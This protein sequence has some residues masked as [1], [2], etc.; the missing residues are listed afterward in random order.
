M[1]CRII[2][3]YFVL[4]PFAFIDDIIIF[5]EGWYDHL[6]HIKNVLESLRK[7]H[8]SAKPSKC[9]FAFLQ[10]EFLAHIVGNGDV[11]PTQEKI[12]AIQKIP[13]PETKKQVRSFIGMIGFYRRFISHFANTSAVLTDLTAK[14]MPNKVKWT[15]IHQNAFNDLKM[16]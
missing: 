8:L 10:I 16:R 11:R 3:S 5:S 1:C 13:I 14:G 9:R 12:E 15:E 2:V 7:A 6:K 4:L